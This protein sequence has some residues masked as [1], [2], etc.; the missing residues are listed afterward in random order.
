[1]LGGFLA[2]AAP[3]SG[4]HSN[5]TC[6]AVFSKKAPPAHSQRRICQ[7]FVGCNGLL[8]HPPINL[9]KGARINVD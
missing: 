2:P 8:R 7:R 6:R 9:L 1:L 4:V 3:L 5:G